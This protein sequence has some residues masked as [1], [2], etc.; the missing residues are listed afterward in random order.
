MTHTSRQAIKL[1]Q[2]AT[3]VVITAYVGNDADKVRYA[4]L[5]D[6]TVHMYVNEV[7]DKTFPQPENWFTIKDDEFDELLDLLD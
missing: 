7:D 4:E 5:L 1:V 6:D 2:Q 3:A